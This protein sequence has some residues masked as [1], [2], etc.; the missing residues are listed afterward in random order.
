MNEIDI[1]SLLKRMGF[2]PQKVGK[3]HHSN[4][5][6][7][8][9]PEGNDRFIV[10]SDGNA[11]CR[12]C[13][14]SCTPHSFE[15]DFF[16]EKRS[17]DIY[18]KDSFSSIKRRTGEKGSL[19]KIVSDSYPPIEWLRF[20][21]D[22][23][24]QA[25]LEMSTNSWAADELRRRGINPE[26]A[27]MFSLGYVK[28][29]MYIPGHEVGLEKDWIWIPQGLFI[30]YWYEVNGK[31][32]VIKAKVRRQQCDDRLPKYVEISGS[33]NHLMMFG[34]YEEKIPVVVESE[35]DAIL[36]LQEAESVIY[37]IA[38]GGATKPVNEST[39]A[40][41]QNASRILLALDQDEAGKSRYFFWRSRYPRARSWPADCAKSPG[42]M[43][44]DRLREWVERGIKKYPEENAVLLNIVGYEAERFGT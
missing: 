8:N 33:S 7:C 16:K 38:L 2:D 15:R 12:R 28:E 42:D 40:L 21:E 34:Y 37:P 29:D 27:E 24:Q 43:P 35:L 19:L 4:C 13:N 26:F 32:L 20:F 1:V 22:F 9:D 6:Y 44:V 5:P 14:K 23:T 31:L 39:D 10:F 25:T 17:R 3:E 11:W 41:L 30:P 36:L 18:P